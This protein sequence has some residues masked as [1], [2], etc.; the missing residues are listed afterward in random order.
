MALSDC[1]ECWQTPCECGHEF[2]NTSQNYKETMTKSINGHTIYDVF[3]WL[4]KNNYL[5]DSS[6]ILYTEFIHRNN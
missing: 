1:S 4:G 3:E 2:K 6:D 5:T